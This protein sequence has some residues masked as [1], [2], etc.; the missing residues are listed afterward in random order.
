MKYFF[1]GRVILEYKEDIHDLIAPVDPAT[2]IPQLN[3]CQLVP[4]D[5]QLLNAFISR[6]GKHMRGEETTLDDIEV[7]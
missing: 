6:A 3:L 4:D 7:Y 2:N 1:R 5:Y